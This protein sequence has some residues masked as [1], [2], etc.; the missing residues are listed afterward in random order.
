MGTTIHNHQIAN[1]HLNK[2]ILDK[3]TLSTF[4]F[5]TSQAYKISKSKT[6]LSWKKR[7]SYPGT[8]RHH[9]ITFANST[10]G[11]LL[12]GSAI[13]RN[14]YLEPSNDFY[15]YDSNSDTWT[16]TENFQGEP[17]SFG[18]GVAQGSN[19][20]LGFGTGKN[21]YLIDFW[22]Y[23]MVNNKFSRLADLPGVGRRHPA[24]VEVPGKI[25][26]GL[27]D[28][29]V[30]GKWQNLADF[31]EYDIL[32]DSW[33]Q[34]ENIPGIARHHPYYFG[35][36]DTVFVGLGHSS[37][38][39]VNDWYKFD[40][41]DKKWTILDD[42]KS[43]DLKNKFATSEGRVA[44]TQGKIDECKLG[45]VL[46]GD[47]DNHGFM[48]EGEFHVYYAESDSWMKLPSH[49]GVS[50]WAPGSFVIGKQVFFTSGVNRKSRRVINDLWEINLESFC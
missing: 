30:D 3:T 13:Q 39:V 46:S 26:V 19:A 31:Y 32:S 2:M 38:G 41:V 27:G 22:K 34:I 35:I 17:R 4:L 37:Q 21:G 24:V 14:G 8:P 1:I 44:G 45:F 18:Y 11:F 5:F 29:V 33:I 48:N 15:I 43:F 49:P 28:G 47:G 40:T 36:D 9:P 10:H 42:F 12:T 16:E 23:D 6:N 20:Y 7:T 25:Y 50:R